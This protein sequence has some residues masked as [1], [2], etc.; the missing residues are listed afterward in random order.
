LESNGSAPTG[1]SARSTSGPSTPMTSRTPWWCR[2]T[3]R[4]RRPRA[5]RTATRTP[6]SWRCA[7]ASALTARP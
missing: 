5:R 4:A 6:G 3:V 1:R 7:R 2:G